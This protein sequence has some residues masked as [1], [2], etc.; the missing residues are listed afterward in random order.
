M[1]NGEHLPN[2]GDVITNNPLLLYRSC[3]PHSAFVRMNTFYFNELNIKELFD[4]NYGQF[5]VFIYFRKNMIVYNCLILSEMI[6]LKHEC[7]LFFF[8]T[9]P[10]HM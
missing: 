9:N 7:A 4:F 1:A 8:N 10:V 3:D 6:F 5:M 2:C